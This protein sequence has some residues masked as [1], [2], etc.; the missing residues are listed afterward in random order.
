[1]RLLDT[2]N[3]KAV[4][5]P[6]YNYIFDKKTGYFERWGKTREDDPVCAPFPE[7]LDVEISTACQKGC[8]F[9]YKDNSVDGENMSFEIFKK[10]FDKFYIND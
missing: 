10:I 1:M 3:I 2:D 7:I 6:N 4:A 5:S 9:C 8:P